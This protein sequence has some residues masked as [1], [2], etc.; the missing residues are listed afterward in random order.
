MT[1]K[2]FV[3][4][5]LLALTV[6]LSALVPALAAQTLT[7][8]AQQVAGAKG[9]TVSVTISIANNPGLRA[10][11]VDILYD[12]QA[13]TLTDVKNEELLKNFLFTQNA[14]EGGLRFA[15]AGMEPSDANGALVTLRFK[16]NAKDGVYPIGVAVT[17]ASVG[18]GSGIRK[19]EAKSVDGAVRV[20]DASEV[21]LGDADGDGKV[22][23]SD[24][25]MILRHAAKVETLSGKLTLFVADV[26]GDG[27]VK[28][29]DARLALRMASRLDA[30][31]TAV[32]PA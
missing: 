2:K 9:E 11:G 7:V 18:D 19:L 6:F 13:L 3:P 8:S 14:V 27:R 1:I 31:K 23:S 10:L 16:I 26:D 24:A 17:Q 20:G 22:R 4:A 28:A 21:T 30:L 5:L 32:C 15:Y 29:M 12:A 25:R